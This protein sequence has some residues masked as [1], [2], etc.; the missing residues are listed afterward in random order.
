MTELIFPLQTAEEVDLFLKKI[1]PIY[2][3]PTPLPKTYCDFNYTE[4]PDLPE[5]AKLVTAVNL[6][7]PISTSKELSIAAKALHEHYYFHTIP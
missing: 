7:L 6:T 1:P 2:S 4:L 5:D 3:I